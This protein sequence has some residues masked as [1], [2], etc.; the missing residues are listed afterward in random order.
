LS[1]DILLQ[2]GEFRSSLSNAC[3]QHAFLF[4]SVIE[5]CPVR[6]LVVR[7]LSRAGVIKGRKIYRA[8]YNKSVD[9]LLL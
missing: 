1:Y 7:K 2:G 9:A 6:L 4:Q 8:S 5:T 3:E